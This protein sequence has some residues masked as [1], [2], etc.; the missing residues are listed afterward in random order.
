MAASVKFVAS[1]SAIASLEKVNTT[2]LKG[3][4]LSKLIVLQLQAGS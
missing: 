4:D 2:G 1:A 3:D